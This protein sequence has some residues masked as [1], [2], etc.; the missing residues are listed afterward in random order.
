MDVKL[1]SGAIGNSNSTLQADVDD[2]WY[3]VGAGSDF[4]NT[5]DEIAQGDSSGT[6]YGG[7]YLFT[8]IPTLTGKTVTDARLVLRTKGGDSGSGTVK[9]NITAEDVVGPVFPINAA[10]AR[11]AV[12]T[13][14]VITWDDIPFSAEPHE[15]TSPNLATII[16]ELIATHTTPTSIII[17]VDDDGSATNKNLQVYSRDEGSSQDARLK[18]NF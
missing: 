18:M 15:I 9:L 4:F 8:S 3:D 6:A 12:R 16:N 5:T 11:G 13:T 17:F 2:G 14:A 1:M 10:D 7:F